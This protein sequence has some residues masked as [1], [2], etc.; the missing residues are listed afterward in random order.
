MS[1]S[2]NKFTHLHVHTHYSL[3]DGLSKIGELLDYVKENGMDS[4]AITDHGNMYGAIEFY[5]A[6]KKRG[7]K[8]IIGIEGYIATGDMRDKRPGIDDKR[9]H[10]VLLA[11]NNTGYKNLIKLTTEAHLEGFYYKPRFDKKL[12]KKYSEGIIALS[13]CLGAEIPTLI[14]NKKIDKAREAI[15]EY[16]DIFGENNFFLEAQSHP[17]LKEQGEVNEVLYKLADETNTPLVATQDSHYTKPEDLEAHDILLAIQTG[18]QITDKNRLTLKDDDFSVKPPAQMIEEFAHRPDAIENTQKIAERCNVEITLGEYQ[19]PHFKVPNGH[20]A[21]SYLRELCEKGL[22]KRYGENPGEEILERLDY[23]LSIIKKTGFASYFL[24]VHDF[25]NWAKQQGIAVGPGRGSAAG[26]I[27]SYLLNVT[28]IDPIEFELLFERFLNPERISMP[29]IDLDFADHRRDEVLEYVS[30][31]Y[32]KDKVAQIITFGTMA[33]RAAIR[34]AGRALGLS[35]DYCD[36]VAKLIPMFYTLDKALNEVTELSELYNSDNEAKRLIDSAR[37]LEG[38]VRHASVHACGVVMTK[39]PLTEMVP[40]QRST[41]NQDSIITQ[42]E[43]HAV[44]DLGLLKMDFLGLKNLTIIEKT[45]NA[46]KVRHNKDVDIE[47]I[48]LDDEKTYKLLQRGDTS[49]VFQLESSGMRRYLKE[50]VPT[51]FEDIIVMISLYRPGPMEL[52]PDYIARKHGKK[53][54][55]YT[56]PKLEPILKNTYG[57]G[58]YQEQMMQIARNLA[59]FSLAEADTLRKAIGKKIKKLLNEQKEKLITGMMDNGIDGKTAQKIWDLFPPF[60]R[61]GFN[62]SHAACYAR[63]AYETAY[64][65]AHYPIE[66]FAAL[67]N[68]EQKNI[69]RLSFIIE[70]ANAMDIEILPPSVNDSGH[71]FTVVDQNTI[72]FGLAAIKNVG[73]NI[74]NEIIEERDNQGRFES[75]EDFLERVLSKDLNKKSLESL[76]KAGALDEFNE[77]NMLL[78]NLDSLL[79][80]SREH[81]SAEASGQANLFAGTEAASSSKLTLKDTK[82]ASSQQKLNW[83][84]EL[85]GF[86]ITGHPLKEFKGKI[87]NI[88]PLRELQGKSTSNK[89]RINAVIHTSKKI[90]TK[91]GKPMMFLGLEDLTGKMEAIIFPNLMEK[92][93]SILEENKVIIAV[94]KVNSRGGEA[95]FICDNIKELRPDMFA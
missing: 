30:E 84:K 88:T 40:L 23:E 46:I 6:A 79:Q 38:V 16:K 25:V 10:I 48:P 73:E 62:R 74:V 34:D 57:V 45:L 35:Y 37:R 43:M 44:E 56:H 12:L 71:D 61:Y 91:N 8:P 51:E 69:D 32:G 31:K 24:I 94:G 58:V 81:K 60:A 29:D 76:I 15:A 68:A 4:I 89:V 90:I 13:G 28:N 93:V 86:Y 22:P 27:V 95:K 14:Q 70:E 78:E 67:L 52:I 82:P 80:Y 50:L 20:T 54:I 87:K 85:L 75:L 47:N 36:K 42:Y 65:K 59:G 5:Q 55:K 17:N 77:R 18:N 26:S 7:V 33:A 1:D 72:R 53:E 11:E 3:L 83:E 9:W 66:F 92:R 49:G 63:I 21:D 39:E 64:L 19:L 2:K 41:Q